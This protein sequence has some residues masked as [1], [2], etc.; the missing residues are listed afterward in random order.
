LKCGKN[1]SGR[2]KKSGSGGQ[3][4]PPNSGGKVEK[5]KKKFHSKKGKKVERQIRAVTQ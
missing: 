3:P 1:Q 5:G 2:S 4:T